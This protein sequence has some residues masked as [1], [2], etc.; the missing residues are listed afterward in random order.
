VLAVLAA[1]FLLIRPAAA[2]SLPGLPLPFD[3][4][5]EGHW[6]LGAELP[7]PFAQ[8]GA[9]PG[10]R[11]TAIDGQP[12]SDPLAAER[13]VAQGPA[14]DV[15]L[16][17]VLPDPA[18]PSSSP[19]GR[20]AAPSPEP[21]ET[22]LVVPR[23]EL[24]H[25]E[26]LGV[27]PW[28]EG[29]TSPG[30]T[31]QATW[32]G[33]PTLTD[34][35]G[36]SW[37]LDAGTGGMRRQE[38]TELTPLVI[39][40]VFWSLSGADWVLDRAE[41]LVEDTTA[42]ARASLSLAARIRS[43]QG[44]PGDHLVLPTEQGL[45]VLLVEWPRGTPALPSCS[46]AVPE[47]CLAAG[48]QVVTDLQGRTGAR[49]E[50]QRLLGLACAG[51]VHRGCYEAVALEDDRLADQAGACVDGDVAACNA[52]ADK[53]LLQHPEAPTDLDVGLLEY[54]CE[55]EG[56]GS[57]GQRLRRLETV[58]K[59]CMTL[60]SVYDKR[61]MPDR[62][63]LNLDQACVLGRADA[64]DEAATRR[65]KAFAAR[66]V[67][68]CED[69][70]LPIA[71][72]CVDLGKLLQKE[73][74]EAAS[75][76][77]FSAFLRGCSLGAA[78]G[79]VLLGDYVDRWGIEN[80]RVAEAERQLRQSCAD[81]EQ[82]ACLG[83][84]HLL[85]RHEP[86]T[87]AYQEALLMFKNACDAGLASACVAGAEQRRI[88]R[89]KDAE[90]PS[91]IEMWNQA[92]DLHSAEGCVG[93]GDR[94]VRS[95]KTWGE[96]YTAWTRACDL[97]DSHACTALGQ[98]VER[99]HSEPW[100]TEQPGDSYLVRGCDNGDPEGCYWL[101]EDDL[102]RKGEPSEP[103]YK[104]L[105]QSCEG[106]Y[107]DGCARLAQVHLDRRTSFDDEIA[108]RHLDT[109]CD[110]GSYDSCKVLGTMYMRGKGVE[111][112]RQEAR[113]LLERFR[114]N[115]PRKHVRLG[116]TGGLAT[117]AGGEAELVLPIPVGPAISVGGTYSYLPGLGTAMMLLKGL[118][119]PAVAPD[120]QSITLSARLYPN[121]Q[122]RGVYGAFGVHQLTASGGDL[123]QALVRS[124]W[125]ARLGFRNDSKLF[126]TGIELGLGQYGLVYLKDF[127]SN[128]TGI[129]PLLLP[130]FN[131]SMGFAFL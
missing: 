7:A 3:V 111:R 28:P 29:F 109:A 37:T 61:G 117:L 62:A 23:A 17:F 113:Q 65:H 116:I 58:G 87:D 96:A 33:E 34:G 71:A 13:A 122:A 66:M 100:P 47:A 22:I 12:F 93:L 102:P 55:L 10:W 51:G 86:K 124:G 106:Q 125:S 94:M 114:L 126:Y 32:S 75:V 8:A 68:E 82:K 90:A 80:P 92:C 27:V 14:R 101:A 123:P 38:G 104:L 119:K 72:S 81:G 74:V 77:D 131:F 54:A 16:H 76:D 118:D 79:C 128:E 112:D 85:V 78:D 26:Q 57:L 83:A 5:A 59:G 98:L 103:D 52:V 2:E 30:T 56:S 95:K 91:Q 99:R 115:A 64:C 43:F 110:N 60:A 73:T 4:D 88:G 9:A 84:G 97:G 130:T 42:D 36:L 6:L 31:W 15:R 24:V 18:A 11:L 40:E 89:A 48:E 25:A 121:T 35:A 19:R 1:A 129:L 107:G 127:D 63:L 21:Q 49:A 70:K 120:I 45:E 46:P 105:D 108:A 67:R 41:G 53:R 50:A 44:V 20:A 69:D 39:P